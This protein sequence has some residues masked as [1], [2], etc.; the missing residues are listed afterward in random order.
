MAV[1]PPGVLDLENEVL[2]M[3]FKQK[4]FFLSLLV[5]VAL[6]GCEKPAAIED[7]CTANGRGDV[8]CEFANKGEKEG[9]KCVYIVLKSTGYRD[10]QKNV[11][12]EIC[13]GI[14]KGGDVVQRETNGGF[15]EMPIDFCVGTKENWTDNCELDVVSNPSESK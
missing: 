2:D 13:S 10:G 4:E 8:S 7:N 11:S 3:A 12:R 9:S 6:A 14:V 15:D 5:S 1:P